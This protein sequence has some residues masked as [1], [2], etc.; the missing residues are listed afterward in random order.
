M[1]ELFDNDGRS[2]ETGGVPNVWGT[3]YDE[4]A[5]YRG[6]VAESVVPIV[7][8]RIYAAI[9]RFENAPDTSMINYNKL[10]MSPS[11]P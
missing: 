8:Q 7:K 2:M 11:L 5:F 10:K 4:E 9:K 6:V 1:F 3:P